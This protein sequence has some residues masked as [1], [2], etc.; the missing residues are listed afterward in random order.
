MTKLSTE[1]NMKYTSERNYRDKKIVTFEE[2]IETKSVKRK[3]NLKK[4]GF[5]KKIIKK[6]IGWFG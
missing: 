5:L 3:K 6:V 2:I 4:D 1:I